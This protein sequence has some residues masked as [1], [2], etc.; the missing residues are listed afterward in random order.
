MLTRN[1]FNM[2]SFLATN[3]TQGENAVDPLYNAID[4]LGPYAIGVVLVLGIIYGIILGVKFAK[5]EDSKE[6][7]ALQKALVSGV[8]GFVA[9][10]LLLTIV[11]AI[12]EPLVDF[13]NS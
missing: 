12:R 9:V 4:V 5:A 6:R 13:M 7:K 11:Y 10:L 1:I 2:I 3:N 8:V